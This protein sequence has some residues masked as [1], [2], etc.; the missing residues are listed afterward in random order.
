MNKY[1]LSV[2]NL[3]RSSTPALACKATANCALRG[4]TDL[5]LS[6]IGGTP[7][8]ASEANDSELLFPFFCFLKQ[9]AV[10]GSILIRLDCRGRGSNLRPRRYTTYNLQTGGMKAADD[11]DDYYYCYAF[12]LKS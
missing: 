10:P 5:N 12:C 6:A 1:R 4:Q 11:D 9:L 8:R 3:K 2:T 7:S